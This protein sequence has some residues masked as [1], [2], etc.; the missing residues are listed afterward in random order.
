MNTTLRFTD[1]DVV[2]VPSAPLT[3]AEKELV[4]QRGLARFGATDPP[5]YMCGHCRA[6]VIDAEIVGLCSNCIRIFEVKESE[7]VRLNDLNALFIRVLIFGAIAIA[8][9][10]MLASIGKQN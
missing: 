8:V 1:N 7:E 3:Q 5:V 10:L 9:G 6:A 2:A 4:A